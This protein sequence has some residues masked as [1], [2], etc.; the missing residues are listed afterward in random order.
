MP[1]LGLTCGGVAVSLA[2]FI[3]V[4]SVTLVDEYTALYLEQLGYNET[5]I[6]LAPIAGLFTQ[7]IGLPLFSYIADKYRVRKL[8]CFVFVF[9]TAPSVLLFLAAPTPKPICEAT[10]VNHTPGNNTIDASWNI[11]YRYKNT[12]AVVKPSPY[13]DGLVSDA[14]EALSDSAKV[15]NDETAST[16]RVEFYVI[17]LIVRGVFEF[18]KRFV[19]TLLVVAAMTH[20][21]NQKSK[22]GH[23]SCWGTVGSGIALFVSGMVLNHVLHY[24]CGKLAPNY[25]VIFVFVAGYLLLT[26][27]TVPFLKFEYL[28]YKVIDYKEVKEFLSTFHFIFLL[29][30]CC[31]SG[32]FRQYQIRWEFWYIEYLGGSPVVMAVSGLLKRSFISAWFLFSPCVFDNFNELKVYPFGLLIFAASFFGMALIK[33]AW[34]ILVFDLSQ[35]LAYVLV[36]VSFIIHFSSFGSKATTAFFQGKVIYD[37]L[38]QPHACKMSSNSFRF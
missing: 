36:Y 20:L 23:Y 14:Y 15:Q 6:G 12:S 2:F 8:L 17:Y 34:L 25:V 38:V 3:F 28:E 30:L 26:L 33:N 16:R 29:A 9:I 18:T 35:A 1:F 7:I 22:F 13:A 21:K 11:T 10:T 24:V 32:W 4:P 31:A 5:L 37:F 19:I 27:L